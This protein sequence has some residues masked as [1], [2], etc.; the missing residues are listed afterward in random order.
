[1]DISILITQTNDFLSRFLDLPLHEIEKLNKNELRLLIYDT[2]CQM[3]EDV[4]VQ[5]E[6]EVTH[7]N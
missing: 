3:P 4:L 5:F 7:G 6:K 1:M 2:L